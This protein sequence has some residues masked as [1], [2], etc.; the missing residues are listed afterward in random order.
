ML[1]ISVKD[2]EKRKIK[3][4]YKRFDEQF[5]QQMNCCLEAQTLYGSI[6]NQ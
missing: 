5:V 2:T 3:D 1:A 6:D 4:E